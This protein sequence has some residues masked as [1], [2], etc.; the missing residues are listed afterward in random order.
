MDPA[1]GSGRRSIAQQALRWLTRLA[2]AGLALASV[3][4]W[5]A[6]LGWPFE[7]FVHFRLQ[8]AVAAVLLVPLLWLVQSRVGAL[9]AAAI[10]ALHGLPEAH[11]LRAAYRQLRELLTTFRLRIDGRGLP[12]A[13]DETIQD[14][15]RRTDLKI[16]LDNRL[17]GVELA[18]SREIHVLQII[19]EALSNIERHAR[20]RNVSVTLQKEPMNLLTVS[21]EDDGIG[22]DQQSAPLHRYG[23][24]IMRDR[25][26]SLAG[27]LKVLPRQGG[28][29]RVQFSFPNQPEP[30]DS[31]A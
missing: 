31:P 8:L 15:R 18:P 5:L 27:E 13:I 3:A 20:A 16:S 6:P 21:I 2:L 14:F 28:G 11:G 10:A 19:R 9:L 22:F 4:A 12:A 24:V 29:T 30:Q 25:A 26:Q 7:L 1:S 23:I 17:T